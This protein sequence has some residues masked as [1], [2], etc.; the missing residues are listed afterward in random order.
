MEDRVETSLNIKVKDCFIDGTFPA[1]PTDDPL[2]K[3]WKRIDN[4]VLTWMRNSISPDLVQQFVH[5]TTTFSLWTELNECYGKVSGPQTIM[6]KRKMVNLTQGDRCVTKYY[7]EL[8]MLWSHYRMLK[9]FPTD[10][11]E[12]LRLLIKTDE[13]DLLIQSLMGLNEEYGHISNQISIMTPLPSIS[14]AYGM[15]CSVETQ[16]GGQG[17][18]G[19]D[20]TSGFALATCDRGFVNSNDRYNGERKNTVVCSY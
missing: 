16:K 6:L 12:L 9:L 4:L 15:V 1:P 20:S 18:L 2:F 7:T 10:N 13:S 17:K 14:T 5:H 3:I 11:L 19:T 8:K